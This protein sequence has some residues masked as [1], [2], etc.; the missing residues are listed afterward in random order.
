M[1]TLT[2]YANTVLLMTDIDGHDSEHE[3]QTKYRALYDHD[4]RGNVVSLRFERDEARPG[5]PENWMADAAIPMDWKV[6]VMKQID[7]DDR[8]E[9][10]RITDL[11]NSEYA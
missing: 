1:K 10:R 2:F 5:K 8:A 11:V 9:Q 3:V 7:D 4:W 6:A